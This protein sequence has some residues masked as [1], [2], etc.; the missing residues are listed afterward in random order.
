MS[1][2]VKSFQERRQSRR[3]DMEEA[4]AIVSWQDDSGTQ[5]VTGLCFDLSRNGALIELAQSP[6]EGQLVNLTLNPNTE[7][8]NKLSGQIRRVQRLDNEH[9]QIGIELLTQ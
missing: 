8:E 9:Y 6:A 4:D 2:P 1:S 3:I 5:Q 7:I